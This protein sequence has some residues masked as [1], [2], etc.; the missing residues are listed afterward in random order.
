MVEEREREAEAEGTLH[1]AGN[2]IEYYSEAKMG[3]DSMLRRNGIQL[4]TY[5]R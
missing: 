4:W 5:S 3:R 2:A 1:R